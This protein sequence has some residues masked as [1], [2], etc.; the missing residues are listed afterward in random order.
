M[1]RD[2]FEG[3]DYW[4][5]DPGAGRAQ[6]EPDCGVC[7]DSGYVLRPPRFW[8]S[9]R[10]VRCAGCN[11]SRWQAA[12]FLWRWRLARLKWKLTPPRWRAKYDDEAPF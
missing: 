1:T 2:D 7:C 9:E 12:C 6:E 4:D 10:M 5:D 8:R 3:P 11:P